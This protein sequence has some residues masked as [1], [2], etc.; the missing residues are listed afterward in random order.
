MPML[1]AMTA[2][3][4]FVV[5]TDIHINATH[6]EL[7]D[8]WLDDDMRRYSGDILSR[9]SHSQYSNYPID[10][11]KYHASVLRVNPLWAIETPE[12]YSTLFIDPIHRQPSPI[13]ALSGVI[14]TD[15]YASEGYLSFLVDKKFNGVI[16]Q[17]T[18]LIQLIPF[19]R[20]DWDSKWSNVILDNRKQLDEQHT[21]L[22]HSNIEHAY[23]KVFRKLKRW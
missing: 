13:H 17:G 21:R 6:P 20:E 3:Y 22:K 11:E 14:D 15:S 4:I 1:D 2:G 12:G 18:P 16:K 10:L 8:F 23:R 9:H 19:K 7:L 5:P